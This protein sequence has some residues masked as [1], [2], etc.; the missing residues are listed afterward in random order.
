MRCPIANSTCPINDGSAP[1]NRSCPYDGC[2]YRGNGNAI[3]AKSAAIAVGIATVTYTVT[4]TVWHFAF[5]TR[6]PPP[7]IDNSL[8]TIGA[9][10]L[11]KQRDTSSYNNLK[12]YLSNSYPE[13]QFKL[14]TFDI[15]DQNSVKY[16]TDKLQKKE[17]D[18]AFA[19]IPVV[20]IAAIDNNYIYFARM[21]PEAPLLQTAIV[22]KKDSPIQTFRGISNLS[23][24][25]RIGLGDFNNIPLY[26]LPIFDLYGTKF[27]RVEVNPSEAL[28]SLY[29]EKNPVDAV[30][31][32]YGA[33]SKN[34]Y[35]Q[36]W[37]QEIDDKNSKYRIISLSRPIPSGSVYLSPKLEER[38]ILNITKSLSEYST[39]INRADRRY[40]IG[41][42][43]D[44]YSSF[45]SIKKRVDTL[46][47]C[48]EIDDI[49]QEYDLTKQSCEQNVKGKILSSRLIY[50]DPENPDK[51]HVEVVIR[52]INTEYAI[53]IR[54]EDLIAKM[55]DALNLSKQ[56][57]EQ[58]L[59]SKLGKLEV[60]MDQVVPV[61]Q[62]DAVSTIYFNF[63]DV[64]KYKNDL[65]KFRLSE[66]T[67]KN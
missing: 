51:I 53:R 50:S 7:P 3:V 34:K 36:E 23:S 12:E 65:D 66:I 19:A 42:K 37:T 41:Q 52:E 26:Y 18:I 62:E 49:K 33:N 20:S 39:R 1:S 17:W 45:R 5:N 31:V 64:K 57:I 59:L 22:V 38:K 32:I 46:K 2:T 54:K 27:V 6:T 56:D 58:N 10:V 67:S 40:E 11:D 25:T 13:Y 44:D 24:P 35:I 61:Q 16:V 21:T 43:E 4:Y 60:E 14:E 8:I 47:K 48:N 29:R 9:L 30:A 63:I 55:R 28:K 15:T